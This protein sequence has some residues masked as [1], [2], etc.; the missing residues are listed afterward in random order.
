MLQSGKNNQLHPMLSLS[1]SL[2]QVWA[3]YMLL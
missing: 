1:G 3:G 2:E